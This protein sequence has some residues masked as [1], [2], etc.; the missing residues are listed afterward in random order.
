MVAL[1]RVPVPGVRDD[2]DI[3][4]VAMKKV[5]VAG[6]Y[7]RG[8]VAENVRNAIIA[9]NNLRSLGFTPF[10]PHLTHFWHFLQPHEIDYWYEYDLE[11]LEMCDAV[12]RLPGESS[13]ADKEVARAG[14]LGRPVFYSFADLRMWR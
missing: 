12:F 4:D 13:G 3:P 14:E 9:G 1:V 7:T 8:D 10:I 11:W 6:P 2:T 5:Y